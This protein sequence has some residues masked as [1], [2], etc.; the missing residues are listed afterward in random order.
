ML[1]ASFAL[2][3]VCTEERAK[4]YPSIEKCIET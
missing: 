4:V 1:E 3:S 2:K